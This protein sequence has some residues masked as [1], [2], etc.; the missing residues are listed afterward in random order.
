MLP[1][2]ATHCSA[3]HSL[4]ICSDEEYARLFARET[5]QAIN[6]SL[7]EAAPPLP[8]ADDDDDDDFAGPNTFGGDDDSAFG[9]SNDDDEK[10]A[11]DAPFCGFGAVSSSEDE[12]DEPTA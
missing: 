5:A 9:G 10:A 3:S 11:A 4:N 8:P 12:D 7:V 1:I 6:A 2:E